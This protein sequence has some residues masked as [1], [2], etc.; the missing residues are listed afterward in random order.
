MQQKNNF[1]LTIKSLGC[2]INIGKNILL[3][4]GCHDV[5]IEQSE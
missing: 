2:I 3:P 4:N 5:I 1:V